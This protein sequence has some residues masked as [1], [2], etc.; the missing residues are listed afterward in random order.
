LELIASEQFHAGILRWS[1]TERCFDLENG[2]A[3]VMESFFQYLL[4]L[5]YMPS[6]GHSSAPARPESIQ[7]AVAHS[8]F[9]SPTDAGLYQMATSDRW[10]AIV[11]DFP[12]GANDHE[13]WA[14]DSLRI[15]LLEL[16]AQLSIPLAW[17]L[18]NDPQW[19]SRQVRFL[20]GS[21]AKLPGQLPS[22]V[23]GIELRPATENRIHKALSCIRQELAPALLGSVASE[24]A[25]RLIR[26][27]AHRSAGDLRRAIQ[28]MQFCL[29]GRPLAL[30]TPTHG[31]A[32][33][34]HTVTASAYW[35]R[36][37]W[38]LEE[39]AHIGLCHT[40]ARIL[41]DK[42]QAE[43]WQSEDWMKNRD[44]RIEHEPQALVSPFSLPNVASECALFLAILEENFLDHFVRVADAANALSDLSIADLIQGKGPDLSAEMA[45][46][47][48]VCGVRCANQCHA[49]ASF[50]P[51]RLPTGRHP[52][53]IIDRFLDSSTRYLGRG[54]TGTLPLLCQWGQTASFIKSELFDTWLHARMQDASKRPLR[55]ESLSQDQI[56]DDLEDTWAHTEAQG[57]HGAKQA[58][59]SPSSACLE[60]ACASR[61][62]TF[63]KKRRLPVRIVGADAMALSQ[64]QSSGESWA[65][66]QARASLQLTA[67]TQCA[68][69]ASSNQ[70]VAILDET[71]SGT[72]PKVP[73]HRA[74]TPA[75]SVPRDALRRVGDQSQSAKTSVDLDL[76]FEQ[77]DD[78]LHGL[79]DVYE[80]QVDRASLR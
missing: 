79:L 53:Q 63:S 44:G 35:M 41:Y 9:A 45:V 33:R 46:Q 48:A 56:Q 60:D 40:I 15:H 78:L 62:Q 30:P 75:N 52:K 77:S 1:T 39:N 65:E 67:S 6:S 54:Y 21:E 18:P 51:I 5:S 23:C 7:T 69:T 71:E 72:E 16:L 66:L 25:E 2:Y 50:R 59:R 80:K 73:L 19:R 12:V 43:E 31:N 58:G 61:S 34:S 27:L 55:H 29:M 14:G 37:L 38:H 47:I 57:S 11:E 42:H 70:S 10:L 68:V 32:S 17:I 22:W 13:A 24:S 28:M 3:S 76:G 36:L 26:E 74:M 4:A 20:F 64:S 8:A 49:P